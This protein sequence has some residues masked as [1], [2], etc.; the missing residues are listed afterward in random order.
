MTTAISSNKFMQ[1]ANPMN[2]FTFTGIAHMTKSHSPLKSTK[3]ENSYM[4]KSCQV[5][6]QMSK[7]FQSHQQKRL[8]KPI[9]LKPNRISP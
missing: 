4:Q 7:Y 8:Q 9:W 1:I 5:Q 2:Q 3:Y 6:T